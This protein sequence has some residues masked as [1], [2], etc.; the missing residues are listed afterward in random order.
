LILPTAL[1]IECL[2]L[3]LGPAH[4]PG[5]LARDVLQSALPETMAKPKSLSALIPYLV[6]RFPGKYQMLYFPRRLY[7]REK[8]LSRPFPEFLL[9]FR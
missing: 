8:A 5:N 3:L 6:E 9:I 2:L 4:K 7:T 1:T